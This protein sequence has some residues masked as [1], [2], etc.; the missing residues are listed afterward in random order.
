MLAATRLTPR[1]AH[2]PTR[3]DP[4]AGRAHSPITPFQRRRRRETTTLEN[5]IRVIVGG[6]SGMG[7]QTARDLV[8]EGRTVTIVARDTPAFAALPA[9]LEAFAPANGRPRVTTVACDLSDR[10]AVARLA[11]RIDQQPRHIDQL[12]NAAGISAP[13]PFLDHAGGDDDRSMELNR[14]MFFVTQAVARN[15][16]AHVGVMAG[17]S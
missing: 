1:T 8:A 2:G 7:P 3:R 4:P 16:K 10:A 17:R 9:E 5:K 6:S 15:M 13:K 14:A 11:Q 12:V